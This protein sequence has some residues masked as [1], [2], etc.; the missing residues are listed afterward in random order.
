MNEETAREIFEHLFSMLETMDTK[1]EAMLQLVR[2]KKLATEEELKRYVDQ[3]G[4]ASSV[5]WL[6]ARARILHL[7]T[8][9]KAADMGTEKKPAGTDAQE[10]KEEHSVEKKDGEPKRDEKAGPAKKD[11]EREPTREEEM[12]PYEAKAQKAKTEDGKAEDVKAEES[13][14]Q[15]SKGREEKASEE[16]S[17]SEQTAPAKKE[18]S[19][20]PDKAKK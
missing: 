4:N 11:E 10:G 20:K 15:E 8:P 18:E 5:R 13:K 17:S 12:A 1:S 19:E 16:K 9:V 3:A 6:G 7:L 2:D 14:R